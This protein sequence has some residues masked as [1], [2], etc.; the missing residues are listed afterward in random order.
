MRFDFFLRL[1]CCVRSF[2]GLPCRSNYLCLCTSLSSDT[3]AL[4]IRLHE[5]NAANGTSLDIAPTLSRHVQPQDDDVDDKVALPSESNDNKSL[6]EEGET[7]LEQHENETE[8][9]FPWKWKLTAL[10]LGV[11]LSGEYDLQNVYQCVCGTEPSLS[12]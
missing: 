12:M 7:E 3:A 2:T 5:M 1:A 11:F 10:A 6:G 8:G 9:D 4:A